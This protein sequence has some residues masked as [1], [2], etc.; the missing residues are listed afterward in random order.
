MDR[1][2]TYY[3]AGPMSGIPDFNFPAFEQASREL[4]S[5]GIKIESP[6]EIQQEIPGTLPYNDVIVRAL[7]L[8]KTCRGII[9]LPGWAGSNGVVHHELAMARQ[10]NMPVLY[11]GY[12]PDQPS[13]IEMGGGQ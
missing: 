10:F 13:L 3:L 6:H 12:W 9:L 1:S 8:L 2:L 11:Y 4:R 5:Q 7:D